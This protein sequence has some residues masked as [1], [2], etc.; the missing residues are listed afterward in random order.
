M[1]NTGPG[2]TSIARTPAATTVASATGTSERGRSSNSSSSTASTTAATGEPK[3]AVMPA[4]AP[5]ASRVLRSLPVTF[6]NWPSTEPSAPPVAMIGP[7]AP[8]GPPVPIAIAEDTGLRKV[9]R[10]A[11][12]DSLRS[13]CSIA[14]GMPWPR[15]AREPQRAIA[16]TTS[17]PS[18]GTTITHAPS[19]CAAGEVSSSETRPWKARLVTSATSPTSS[20]ATNAAAT[21]SSA[22]SAHSSSTRGSTRVER[23]GMFAASSATLSEG[24]TGSASVCAWSRTCGAGSL[25]GS[26]CVIAPAGAAPS[27]MPA[28]ATAAA[29][30]RA[31]G[32]RTAPSGRPRNS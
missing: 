20:C 27:P 8:N 12:F 16:P 18:T 21:P 24:A 25:A 11:I 2:S 13:T 28:A 9:T 14:S 30:G 19:A 6:S 26:C 15:I 4:A 31:A 29:S 22:A 10:G 5:A 1:A 23:C 3:I 7:S 32:T 17:P